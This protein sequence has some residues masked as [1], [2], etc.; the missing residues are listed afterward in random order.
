MF[1]LTAFTVVVTIVLAYI[2]VSL[3]KANVVEFHPPFTRFSDRISYS[4]I[5]SDAFN[6]AERN[7]DNLFI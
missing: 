6:D 2:L 3:I 7:L 4:S 5:N 1:L